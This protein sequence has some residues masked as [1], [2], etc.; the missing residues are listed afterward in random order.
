MRERERDPDELRGGDRGNEGA[1]FE[2]ASAAPEGSRREATRAQLDVGPVAEPSA[3]HAQLAR[4][5]RLFAL[6]LA[7][8][9]ALERGEGGSGIGER[10]E[11]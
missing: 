10:E 4:D 7:C 5:E 3:D 9:R 6:P 8:E 2:D 11:R 1:P